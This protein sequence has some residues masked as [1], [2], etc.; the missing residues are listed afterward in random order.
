MVEGMK[1]SGKMGSKMVVDSTKRR[2]SFVRES[3][4]MDNGLNG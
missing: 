3:G 1:V 2:I 4:K